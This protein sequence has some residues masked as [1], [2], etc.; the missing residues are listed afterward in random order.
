MP[1]HYDYRNDDLFNPETHHESSDVPTRALFWAMIFFVGFSVVSGFVVLFLYKAF[2]NS[3]RKQNEAPMTSVAR[4]ANA[5]VPQNQPL[6]QPFPK[7]GQGDEPIAP[8]SN[9]PVTD[10]ADM[11]RA[12]DTVLHSY[13]YVD[14]Q[15][16]IVRIPIDEAK[17]LVL[18][19]LPG[20]PALTPQAEETGSSGF[21][22]VPRSSSAPATAP[23]PAS[24]RNS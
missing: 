23:A 21:L 5:Y 11:R 4:P 7:K 24:P 9:T 13:G 8:N 1:D 2:V 6:L 20:T 15:K 12:E 3:E 18:G 16:G 14:R 10:L 22:G 19:R 17:E